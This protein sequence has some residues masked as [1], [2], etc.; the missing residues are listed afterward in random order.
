MSKT[1]EDLR[2]FMFF[3][4]EGLKSG[5]LDVDRA[6]AMSEIAQTVI[7]SAKVEVEAM[8]VAGATDSGFMLPGLIPDAPKV[9]VTQTGAGQKTVQH[10]D[11]YSITSH[12]MR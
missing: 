4:L 3:A 11:G 8:R 1:V 10:G 5:E 9:V 12:R 6:K 7:N 2:D